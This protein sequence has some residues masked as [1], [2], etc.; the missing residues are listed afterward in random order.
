MEIFDSGLVPHVPLSGIGSEL[1]ENAREIGLEK[2]IMKIE[3]ILQTK[4]E[5]KRAKKLSN[6]AIGSIMANKKTVGVKLGPNIIHEILDALEV[7]H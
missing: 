5:E 1:F 6:E 2:Y 7:K 3:K 4:I